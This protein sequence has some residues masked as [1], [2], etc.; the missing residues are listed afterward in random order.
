M[1]LS[2]RKVLLHEDGEVVDQGGQFLIREAGG[3][4]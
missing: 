3:Q 2:L 1:V 4:D